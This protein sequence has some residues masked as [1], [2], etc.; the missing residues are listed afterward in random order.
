MKKIY[1]LFE[2]AKSRSTGEKLFYL[3]FTIY[4]LLFASCSDNP[5]NPTNGN[6]PQTNDSLM[7]EKDSLVL[8]S[9]GID[10]LHFH[11]LLPSVDSCRIEFTGL[12]NI[13]STKGIFSVA[14]M[15]TNDSILHPPYIYLW[16]V[17][18]SVGI[19]DFNRYHNYY[20]PRNGFN[21]LYTLVYLAI[22]NSYCTESKYI[23]LKNIKIYKVKSQ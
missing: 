1:N 20:Y 23:I 15:S 13:D 3:L 2:F 6:P 14:G 4:C 5:V 18:W 16:A 10:S 9:T 19:T 11:C 12:T 17:F 8:R 7:L 21:P 22:K